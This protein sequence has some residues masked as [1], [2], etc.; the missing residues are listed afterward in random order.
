MNVQPLFHSGTENFCVLHTCFPLCGF[1]WIKNSII[2]IDVFFDSIYN[3][4]SVCVKSMILLGKNLPN[5]TIWRN[6]VHA[7]LILV[8]HNV[9]LFTSFDKPLNKKEFNYP[10]LLIVLNYLNIRLTIF[11][12]SFNA[13]V[14]D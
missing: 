9:F 12:K 14:R 2:T 4:D 7:C 6:I 3:V 11:N 13:L 5:C 10:K 8:R 1:L